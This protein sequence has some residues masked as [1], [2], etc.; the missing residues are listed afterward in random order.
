MSL[1]TRI[2]FIRPSALSSSCLLKCLTAF[3][4]LVFSVMAGAEQVVTL[5]TR[6]GVTQS[7]LLLYPNYAI[8]RMAAILFPGGNG[9]IGMSEVNGTVKL[10]QGGNFLVRTRAMMR[11]ANFA[12]AVIDAPSDRQNSIGMDDT[13]RASDAHSTDIRAVMSDLADRFPGIEFYLV[14]TSRGTISAA[15]LGAKIGSAVR[16]VVL[17]SALTVSDSVTA[18]GLS[19]FDYRTIGSKVLMVGNTEDACPSTPF[20]ATANVS[21]TY[22]FPLITVHGGLPPTSVVLHSVWNLTDCWRG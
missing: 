14:G 10:A 16:G 6:A 12:V 2:C 20:S 13:F 4:A 1:Q 21:Q 15:N 17:T 19:K 7:Y 22:G 5:P 9:F 18:P 11:D 8:P 3:V